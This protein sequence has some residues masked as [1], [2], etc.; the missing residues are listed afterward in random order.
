MLPLIVEIIEE[1]YHGSAYVLT[2]LRMSIEFSIGPVGV[3][4]SV[5]LGH[6][7]VDN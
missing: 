3:R 2:L 6:V 4:Q 7:R 5:E 1:N